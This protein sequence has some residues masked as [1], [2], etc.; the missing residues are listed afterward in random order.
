[1]SEDSSSEEDPG[2]E[3]ESTPLL[4]SSGPPI[5]GPDEVSLHDTWLRSLWEAEDSDDAAPPERHRSIVMR[6]RMPDPI[7]EV[8]S[9]HVVF[10]SL[11][12]MIYG[13]Y[14]ELSSELDP[15]EYFDYDDYP[16]TPVV[17]DWFRS[18]PALDPSE[19]PEDET[20]TICMC[21][22]HAEE[23]VRIP[24]CGHCFHRQCIGRWFEQRSSC[25]VCRVI[26][27]STGEAAPQQRDYYEVSP[28]PWRYPSTFRVIESPSA[29]LRL[30]SD[31]GPRGGEREEA[32]EEEEAVLI[33]ISGLFE[34]L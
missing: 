32:A 1:M 19:A 23:S 5:A 30:L 9:S 3:Q 16:R 4:S 25:P 26:C 18:L 27:C 29:P 33:D 11:V 28:A 24:A 2:D 31:G 22:L 15:T 17:A 6:M 8:I 21:P 20:C 12:N 7:Q 14:S 13:N 34:N 10:N